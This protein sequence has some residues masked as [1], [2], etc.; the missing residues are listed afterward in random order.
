MTVFLTDRVRGRV[1]ESVREVA[2]LQLSV[3]TLDLFL[4]QC[5]YCNVVTVC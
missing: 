4:K 5:I 1:R 2:E 3:S